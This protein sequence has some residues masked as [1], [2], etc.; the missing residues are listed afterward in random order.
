MD[1]YCFHPSI[2]VKSIKCNLL[3]RLLT[4]QSHQSLEDVSQESGCPSIPPVR[5]E[6]PAKVL[7]GHEPVALLPQVK[8]LVPELL[9]GELCPSGPSAR[10]PEKKFLPVVFL[11]HL[12]GPTR[13]ASCNV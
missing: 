8:V 5:Q 2:L 7:Q 13:S 6:H 9:P 1:K 10:H 11:L 12:R 4:A 3:C